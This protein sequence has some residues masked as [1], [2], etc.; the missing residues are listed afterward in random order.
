M[1]WAKREREE[2]EEV[3][4]TNKEII[5]GAKVLEKAFLLQGN[6]SL[7]QHIDHDVQRC[8]L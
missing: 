1:N 6:L 7:I 2:Q 5:V 3:D 4:P 8:T